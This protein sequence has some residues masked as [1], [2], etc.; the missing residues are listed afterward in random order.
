MEVLGPFCAFYSMH[1]RDF[2]RLTGPEFERLHRHMM[3]TQQETE[4]LRQGI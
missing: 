3:E 1:P 4:R 2:W